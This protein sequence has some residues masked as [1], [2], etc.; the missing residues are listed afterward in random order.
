MAF[1]MSAADKFGGT[2]SPLGLALLLLAFLAGF[3]TLA[4]GWISW[5]ERAS[6]VTRQREK[7]L[8]DIVKRDDIETIAPLSLEL[9]FRRCMGYELPSNELRFA[10]RRENVA[11]L[12]R[13][14]RR[15]RR[16]T[17]REGDGY[18]AK[19]RAPLWLL[20]LLATLIGSAAAVGCVGCVVYATKAQAPVGYMFALE[21]AAL[22]W[23]CLDGM[24][25]AS[26]AR[27]LTDPANYPAAPRA[28]T[29]PSGEHA[30][31]SK[32]LSA[33]GERGK[34]AGKRAKASA[35]DAEATKRVVRARDADPPGL[36]LVTPEV[37]ADGDAEASDK[38]GA[39]A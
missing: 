37:A 22:V 10:L 4:K 13:A 20:D 8:L 25:A 35:D 6:N 16:F 18:A 21:M 7:D 28:T 17:R 24:L 3:F 31:P 2:D 26:G 23:V 27:F 39:P 30:E 36:S 1:L 15:G 38:Q 33:S 19:G 5:R 34:G 9:A 12:L 11:R 14:M 32:R 29:T